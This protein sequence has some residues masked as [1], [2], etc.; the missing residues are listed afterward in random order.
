MAAVR[1]G[2]RLQ[3]VLEAIDAKLRS[4][5]LVR[6]GFF[7]GAR[8]P[9]GTP[10]A[11]VAALQEFGAPATG[12]PPRPFF[13]NMIAAHKREWPGAAARLLRSNDYDVRLTLQMV[14]EG[15]AGQLRQSITDLIAPSLSPTTLMIRK[16]LWKNP[17]LVVTRRTVFE[18]RRRVQR[19]ESTSGVSTKPLVWTGHMLAS[20]SYE[21]R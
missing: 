14:G 3:L 17:N 12:L 1:G 6:I 9:D 7:E 19:G 15:I 2:R 18:A 20:I 5:D 13:R 11:M 21:V 8:Y 10:V 16:M 4:G